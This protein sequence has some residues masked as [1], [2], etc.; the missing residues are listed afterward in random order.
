GRAEERRGRQKIAGDCKAVL[1]RAER[2]VRRI[3]ARAALRPAGSPTGDRERRDDERDEAN[4]RCH[5]RV[6]PDSSSILSHAQIT[7]AAMT[8]RPTHTLSGKPAKAAVKPAGDAFPIP[9]MIVTGAMTRHAAAANT[10]FLRLMIISTCPAWIDRSTKS[11]P[12]RFLGGLP[13][14]LLEYLYHVVI[15]LGKGKSRILPPRSRA[16]AG[17]GADAAPA[18]LARLEV[19]YLR[20]DSADGCGLAPRGTAP[21]LGRCRLMA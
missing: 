10:T 5:G 14:C 16:H 3:Y 15:E 12:C 18:R 21:R 20:V 9:E 19:L 11:G 7:S 17:S 2:A 4:D 8:V 13:R 1:C 6:S